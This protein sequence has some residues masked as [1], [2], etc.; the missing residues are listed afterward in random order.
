MAGSKFGNK[1][2]GWLLQ[3][4]LHGLLDGSTLLVSVT[5]RISGKPVIT[6]VNYTREGDVLWVTSQ[7]NR[8]WWKNCRK[9]TQV[10]LLLK[11]RWV[12]GKVELI[13]EPDKVVRAFEHLFTFAPD[14]AKMYRVKS[15]SGDTLDSQKLA[16]LSER[17]VVLK[18]ILAAGSVH[19]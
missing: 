17:S 9:C 8:Q 14:L 2:V 7:R 1:M 16:S 13:D 6:P 10:D 15:A 5:G 18:I 19:S 4:P 11:G 3:S 12:S